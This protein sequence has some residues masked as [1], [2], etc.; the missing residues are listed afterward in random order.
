M[1]PSVSIPWPAL[2]LITEPIA[3]QLRLF[4]ILAPLPQF[5]SKLLLE[6]IFARVWVARLENRGLRL[7]RIIT[8]RSNYFSVSSLCRVRSR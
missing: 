1:L 3:S 5:L 6:E 4:L 8:G 2:F 7:G